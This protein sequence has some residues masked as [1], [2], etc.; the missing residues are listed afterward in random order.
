MVGSSLLHGAPHMYKLLFCPQHDFI[1]KYLFLINTVFK[2]ILDKFYGIILVKKK[3]VFLFPFECILSVKVKTCLAP[4][5]SD[6]GRPKST[7]TL[8]GWETHPP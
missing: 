4:A 6:Q 5:V 2:K 7:R 8:N 3:S 1:S